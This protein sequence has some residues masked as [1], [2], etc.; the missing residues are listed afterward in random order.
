MSATKNPKTKQGGS[1]ARKK[2]GAPRVSVPHTAPAVALL[3]GTLF[4]LSC[5][6]GV[7]FVSGPPSYNVG[8]I[9]V[10]DVV[11]PVDFLV[12]D[13]ASTRAK[14]VQAARAEPPV[15]DLTMEPYAALNRGVQA[16]FITVSAAT[17][18]TMEDVRWQIAEDLNSEIPKSTLQLWRREDFQNMVLA[19]VLPWMRD[20]M[21]RGVVRDSSLMSGFDR[22]VSMRDAAQGTETWVENPATLPDVRRVRAELAQYL[23]T[24]LKK[25]LVIR[26][27]VWALVGP[28]M[29]PT[30]VHNEAETETRVERAV[31]AVGPMYFH[32]R[33]GEIVV[34]QGEPVTMEQRI[35]LAAM[36]ERTPETFTVRRA[37]GIFMLCGLFAMGLALAPRAGLHPRFAAKDYV[38]LSVVMLLFGGLAKFLAMAG[39][40]LAAESVRVL[41]PYSLPVPAAAGVLALFFPHAVS[42]FSLMLVSFLCTHM[43]G[44]DLSLFSFYFVSGVVQVFAVKMAESRSELMSTVL[45]L[46]VCL[47]LAWVG[48][49]F[50]DFNGMQHA[51]AGGAY[52]LAGGVMSLILVLSLSPI[53]EL[54]LGYTSRFR[55]MELMSL[56]QPL[57]RELMVGAPG[58]YHHSIVVSNMVEAGARAIGANPLLAKV[59]ALYHDVGKLSKPQYFIENQMGGVNRHDKLSPSMSALILTS[60]VKQGIEMARTHK[61]GQEIEDCIRQHHGTMLIS[62][63]YHKAEE[64]A[65][66]RGE[67]PPREEGFRY[68]GPKPQTKE[69]GLLLLAD[70][71]EASSR[72]LVEPTPSRI[73]GHI[74]KTIRRIFLEGQLDESA[75]TLKDLHQISR[76]FEHILAGIFHQR[77]K[78]PEQEAKEA[79]EAKEAR[80]LKEPKEAKSQES[81]AKDANSGGA[82]APVSDDAEPAEEAEARKAEDRKGRSGSKPENDHTGQT[83]AKG[84]GATVLRFK[85]GRNG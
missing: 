42:I 49:N 15:F 59:A 34:R 41:L 60:H 68:P 19:R 17:A 13:V 53:V 7:T 58:T 43:L 47:S 45:P 56:E 73:R 26:K 81:G 78:Y 30:L 75:L 44:G 39:G 3:L 52:V 67:S 82:K 48:V 62:Y 63:F 1:A 8:D 65:K 32:V 4:V 69:A 5:L 6:A 70:A 51:L 46:L 36:A 84:D 85:A 20:Y 22:G 2:D 12:E 61:L 50:L 16:V 71:I 35:K 11:A 66:E 31:E 80:E 10:A 23:K 24:E 14:R 83:A 9:A 18:G 76:V 33:Q 64:R 79:K 37:V 74:E 28:Q 57:M 25:P 40:P 77:I 54:A 72:T 21:Q 29:G 27:A 38:L 55:L